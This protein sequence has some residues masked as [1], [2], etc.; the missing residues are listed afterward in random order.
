M[1]SH[2]KH[3]TIRPNA[4]E[5]KIIH[6]PYCFIK[7][8]KKKC[9]FE[10]FLSAMKITKADFSEAKHSNMKLQKGKDSQEA[11]Y[12]HFR[13]LHFEFFNHRQEATCAPLK[14]WE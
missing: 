8:I 10:K 5:A 3:P 7:F 14:K 12:L 6:F 11:A 1:Q 9:A 4:S 13:T 2:C